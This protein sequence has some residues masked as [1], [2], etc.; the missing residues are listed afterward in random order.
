MLDIIGTLLT[1]PIFDEKGEMTSPGEP[2]PGW[3]VNAPY[4]IQGWKPYEVHPTT[5]RRV[6][7][8]AETIFYTF[9][10]EDVFKEYTETITTDKEGNSSVVPKDLFLET[11]EPSAP[12]VP[13]QVS[14]RQIRQAMSRTP[15]GAGTLREVVEAA[16]SQSDQ[17]LQDWWNSSTVFERY[18]S[19]VEIMAESLLVSEEELDALWVLAGSL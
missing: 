13:L 7:A 10:T 18:N 17:D 11:E 2:I 16:V 6:F 8:G 1:E 3:H 9:P 4:R 19:Q 12:A 15:H 14:P 5:P